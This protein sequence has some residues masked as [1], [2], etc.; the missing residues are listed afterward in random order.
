MIVKYIPQRQLPAQPLVEL[1]DQAEVKRAAQ[2]AHVIGS[3][4]GERDIDLTEAWVENEALRQDAVRSQLVSEI[5]AHGQSGCAVRV[6]VKQ[7]GHSWW[8]RRIGNGLHQIREAF[9]R[10]VNAAKHIDRRIG[11]LNRMPAETA[12]ENVAEVKILQ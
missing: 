6:V 1:G 9:M 10:V 4:S 12:S 8:R 7:C 2:D 11:S 5:I 3:S